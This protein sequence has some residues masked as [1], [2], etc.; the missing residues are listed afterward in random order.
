M[1]KNNIFNSTWR[2][3]LL[4]SFK[5]TEIRNHFR[6]ACMS[7]MISHLQI[8]KLGKNSSK[9]AACILYFECTLRLSHKPNKQGNIQMHIYG[10]GLKLQPS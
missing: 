8:V 10:W 6:L 1:L 3:T 9:T 2:K 7:F 4:Y 5:F